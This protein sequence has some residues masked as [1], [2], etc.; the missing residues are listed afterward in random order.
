MKRD[1]VFCMMQTTEILLKIFLSVL[2]LGTVWEFEFCVRFQ[3]KMVKHR[4]IKKPS[5]GVVKRKES[6]QSNDSESVFEALIRS[7]LGL[8]SLIGFLALIISKI[9][10]RG[11]SILI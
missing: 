9:D 7:G 4:T 2:P 11:N 3:L 5:V 8:L 6:S 1:E 10:I